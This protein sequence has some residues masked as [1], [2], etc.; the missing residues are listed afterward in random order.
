MCS[1]CSS[2][3]K[4]GV[5][6]YSG[7]TRETY[8]RAR[9]SRGAYIVRDGVDGDQEMGV[10]AQPGMH[11]GFIFGGFLLLNLIDKG[12]ASNLKAYAR[13]FLRRSCHLF[14]AFGG[15]RSVFVGVT[16][17]GRCA[18]LSSPASL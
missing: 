6:E 14:S 10:R 12:G 16:C 5:E 9:K 18:S 1:V 8:I 3:D 13:F 4:Q 17:V 7:P 15:S 11:A 2:E